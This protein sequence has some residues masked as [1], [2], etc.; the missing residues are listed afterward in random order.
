MFYIGHFFGIDRLIEGS[1]WFV[2]MMPLYMIPY[3]EAQD[4]YLSRMET[5]P[6]YKDWD[7]LYAG[8][9]DFDTI[10]EAEEYHLPVFVDGVIALRGFEWRAR[11][12]SEMYTAGERL[13]PIVVTLPYFVFWAATTPDGRDFACAIGLRAWVDSLA[14]A[15]PF[16]F[17]AKYNR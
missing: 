2:D 17:D 8:Y 14:P 12:P 15:A 5:D 11:L 7:P 3:C 4:S 1:I 10:R 13:A 6:G 9:E 16:V